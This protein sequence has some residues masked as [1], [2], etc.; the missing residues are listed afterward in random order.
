MTHRELFAL[1]C[2]SIVV[3]WILGIGIVWATIELS[4]EDRWDLGL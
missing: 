1:I 4:D 3:G 2:V